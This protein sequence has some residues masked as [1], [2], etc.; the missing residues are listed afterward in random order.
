MGRRAGACPLPNLPI[1][2]RFPFIR[3]ER[4]SNLLAIIQD[5]AAQGWEGGMPPSLRNRATI[6]DHHFAVHK[7]VSITDHEGGILCQFFRAA[8]ATG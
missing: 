3:I 1:Y 7:T 2:S 8:G 5:H 6:N 4:A